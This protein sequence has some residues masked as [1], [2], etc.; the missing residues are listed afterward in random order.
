MDTFGAV[1][2]FTYDALPGRV[3]FGPG[4][5][6]RVADEIEALN[7][8]RVLVI[9]AGSSLPAGTAL[10]DQLGDRAVGMFHQVRQHVP[11]DLA[12]AA[13]QLARELSA[14]AVLAVGGGST[15]G[16]GKAVA[17][18]TSAAV[19]AVPTTYSGSEMTSIYGVTGRH[20]R[21]GRDRLA[22]PRLVVYDPA[23]TTSLP[24]RV[25]AT[26]GFNALAH[27]VEALYAPGANPVTAL[28]A[29]HGIRM[30]ARALPVA[31]RE[32]SNLDARST[33]LF[34][35]YLAGTALAVAGTALHHKLCH[36]LGGTF[37]LVHGDVNAVLLPHVVAF[38]QAAVPD[39]MSD[40]AAA[41][42]VG[43]AAESGPDGAAGALAELAAALGAP[44]RL[45]DLGMPSDRLDAAARR[46]VSEVGTSNPRPV[47]VEAC[48][49]LL[50]DAYHGRPPGTA[51]G[52]SRTT[53]VRR[54]S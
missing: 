12:A 9:A 13:S 53:T 4:A 17:V 36:V 22:L 16:L 33:A 45:V 44:T 42:D 15:I 8:R 19:V 41:L 24:A 32:P 28:H 50:A 34:G 2:E 54:T 20:K 29:T 18:Q 6:G 27:C 49:A 10:R 31:V 3:V 30:L 43:G 51:P 38:N 11:A 46:A 25:T 7:L 40:V 48:R 21:V 37:G 52:E 47:D 26:S 1:G 23:L 5:V 35:A 39:V 14:D